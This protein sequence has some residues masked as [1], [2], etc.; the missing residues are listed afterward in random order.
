MRD[1]GIKVWT[2][3]LKGEGLFYVSAFLYQYEIKTMYHFHSIFHQKTR[4]REK[5]NINNNLR[6]VQLG[7]RGG[8]NTHFGALLR[9]MKQAF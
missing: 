6:K 4:P 2:R 5:S 9:T 1:I 8:V 7:N 3:R